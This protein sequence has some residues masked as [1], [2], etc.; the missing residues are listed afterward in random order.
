MK[1]KTEKAYVIYRTP[2]KEPLLEFQKNS[3]REGEER[4][5]AYSKK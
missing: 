3:R 1:K 5:K 2:S 4:L